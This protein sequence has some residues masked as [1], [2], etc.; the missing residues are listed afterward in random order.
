[1]RSSTWRELLDAQRGSGLVENN[2]LAGEGGG[3]GDGHR[4]SLTAGQ[5]LHGLAH[6]LERAD[7]KLRHFQL[8]VFHHSGFVE[9]AEDFAKNSGRPAFST[10][11]N[12]LANIESRSHCERLIDGFNP[13]ITRVLR[14]SEDDGTP[15]DLHNAFVRLYRPGEAFDQRGFA[16]AIVANNGKDFI[17]IQVE[18]GAIEANDPPE[19]LD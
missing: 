13:G 3:P 17:R 9:L 5:G 8:G 1:M 19:G 12:I 11:I 6:V 18:V 4:L 16:G 2:D 10:E 14:P 15:V 7:P